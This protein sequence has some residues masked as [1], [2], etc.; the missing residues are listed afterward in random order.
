MWSNWGSVSQ[1]T[2]TDH[3]RFMCGSRGGGPPEKSQNIGFLSNTGQN[4][5][6]NHKATKPAFN[7]GHHQP[8]S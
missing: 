3:S 2:V 8:A 1:P 5:L 7:V 4:P 6:K